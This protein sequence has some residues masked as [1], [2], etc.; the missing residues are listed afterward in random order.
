MYYYSEKTSKHFNINLCFP[1]QF[2]VIKCWHSKLFYLRKMSTNKTTISSFNKFH[3]LDW[4]KTIMKSAHEKSLPIS[5]TQHLIPR[6]K[7]FNLIK[8]YIL[9]EKCSHFND[10]IIIHFSLSFYY[11]YLF[12]SSATF[13][14]THLMLSFEHNNYAHHNR[15][16]INGC[17]DVRLCT[18]NLQHY[19]L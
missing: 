18:W 8:N 4:N 19:Y 17:I 3:S 15:I 7:L 11:F 5:F 2:P 12:S 10:I 13:I 9:K 1:E 14:I 6:K 16:F